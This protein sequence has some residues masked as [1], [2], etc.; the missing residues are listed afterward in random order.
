MRNDS[1]MLKLL[2]LIIFLSKAPQTNKPVNY[3]DYH[4][5][6]NK[7][8]ELIIQRKFNAALTSLDEV[9]D[10]YDFVFVREYKIAAQ[11]ALSKADTVKA[12]AY[13]KK[14]MRMGWPINEVKKNK[15]LKPLMLSPRGQSLQ[16]QSK[17]LHLAYLNRLNDSIM[18]VTEEM[19]K[20][21]Q[22]KAMGALLRIGDRAQ[23]NYGNR[24]FAPHSE[25]QLARLEKILECCG[26][27]GEKLIGND[28]WM[29]TIL[30]HHNSISKD[31]VSKDT[32]YFRLKPMLEIA[33]QQG[34]MSTF[35]F[36]IIED[37][38]NAVETQHN[39]TI[40]G[41]LGR[42]QSEQALAQVELNRKRLGLRSIATRNALLDLSSE[43]GM[44]FYLPGEPWQDGKITISD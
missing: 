12:L 9:F 1:L 44:D 37:W 23:E 5:G 29:S 24:K 30:S 14:G 36:A 8:E 2:L 16:T 15:F 41:F 38:K 7:A 32:L 11:L 17:I 20:K 35:E 40:Y 39:T 3:R 4:K 28:F 6:I 31:Y 33:L 19:F 43:T 25:K 21:D 34:E 10:S 26:Y 18:Q 13:L 42:I 27:P 22:K